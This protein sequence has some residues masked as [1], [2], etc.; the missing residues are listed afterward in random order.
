MFAADHNAGWVCDRLTCNLKRNIL[1]GTA[2]YFKDNSHFTRRHVVAGQDN[3]IA[4]RQVCVVEHNVLVLET[5][6][7]TCSRK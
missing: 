1:K 4:E 6:N 3:T 7:M 2:T 5:V